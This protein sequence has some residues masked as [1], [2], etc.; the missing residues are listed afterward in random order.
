VCKIIEY[1]IKKPNTQVAVDERV[2]AP[3]LEIIGMK[4]LIPEEDFSTNFD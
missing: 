3:S 4:I 2:K 1:R